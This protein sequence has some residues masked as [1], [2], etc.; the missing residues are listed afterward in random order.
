MKQKTSSLEA[1][2]RLYSEVLNDFYIFLKEYPEDKCSNLHPEME[3]EFCSIYKVCEHIIVA[4]NI[5]T[6]YFNKRLKNDTSKPVLEVNIGSHNELKIC[7]DNVYQETHASLE[8]I[9]A[10]DYEKVQYLIIKTKW[11]VQYDIESLLE[12]AIVHVL[13]H[14]RQ[15]KTYF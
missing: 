2:L 10:W 5:Y 1:T 9:L 8:K 15:I 12:H 7:L 4:G 14:Q 3:A 11:G 13:R 6:Y